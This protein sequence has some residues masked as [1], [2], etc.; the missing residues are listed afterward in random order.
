M[1]QVHYIKENRKVEMTAMQIL[2]EFP[3]VNEELLRH[4]A[5]SKLCIIR[6]TGKVLI[7]RIEN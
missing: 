2:Q 4:A 6:K 7:R 1:F 3:D 5:C